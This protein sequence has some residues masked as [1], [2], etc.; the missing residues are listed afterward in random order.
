M[1]RK[2]IS[3]C[4]TAILAVSALSASLVNCP[5]CSKP[6]SS[7]AV[8]CPSCGCPGEVIAE[9]AN[10]P[11]KDDV[12]TPDRLIK[13][14]ADGRAGFAFPVEMADGLFAVAPLDFLLSADSVTLTFA[15]TNAPIVYAMPEVALDAP[16]AR[17]PITE[18]NFAYWCAAPLE[19]S[20]IA[21]LDYSAVTG[22]TFGREATS[23]SL[24][25][26]SSATNLVSLFTTASGSRTAQ[27]L[28]PDQK[29]QKIQ[30]KIFREQSR[31][32]DKLLRG[33]E[34]PVPE[35][36]CHPIFEALLKRNQAKEK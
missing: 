34:A 7:R 17:F 10:N 21:N 18:T 26:V 12:K 5:D 36:W 6:V 11:V 27:R 1:L 33:E 8:F 32:F 20:G 23:R 24:A 14:E 15:S 19:S 3:F 2:I 22:I 4:I 16:L 35:K 29:W 28:N 31:V 9:A 30:P 25:A 13:I